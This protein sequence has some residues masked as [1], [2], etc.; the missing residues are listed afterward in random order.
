M[1][2]NIKDVETGEYRDATEE[3]LEMMVQGINP[4]G[5]GTGSI[6]EGLPQGILTP[7]GSS[8]TGGT[9]RIKFNAQGEEI[10]G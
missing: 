4:F 1:K 6:L 7:S 10:N 2:N 5:A 3:E 9:K 8:Q